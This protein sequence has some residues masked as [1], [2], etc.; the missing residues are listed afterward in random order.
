MT[1]TMLPSTSDAVFDFTDLP[2]GAAGRS[3]ARNQAIQAYLPLATHIAR[4]YAGRGE[5]LH[6]LVQ[7]A[8]I[9]L[10][11]AV[12]RFDNH[13][14]VPFAAY[15]TPTILGEVK[16][17]FRD[18]AWVIRIPRGMQEL[19]AR[20]GPVTERLAHGLGH[21]PSSAEVAGGLD[22]TELD[23]SAARRS[24][25]AYRPRSFDQ[26]ISVGSDAQLADSL[27]DIDP[28]FDA[29]NNRESLRECLAGLPARE[30]RILE[31]RFFEGMTQSQ[32]AV[33]VGLSQMQIS[34]LLLRALAQLRSVMVGEP[35]SALDGHVVG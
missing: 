10:I 18:S 31:L 35:L 9:G 24:A 2:L 17:Y 26:P 28:G 16:R 22:V 33:V 19:S 13:R 11:K 25:Y 27:G 8:V 1:T 15:A 29:V 6:D 23:V 5:P 34:R 4:R 7:V 20:I 3:T 32:I 21:T 14:G 12:D 30:Q